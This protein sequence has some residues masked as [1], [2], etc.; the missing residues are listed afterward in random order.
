MRIERCLIDANW[1]ASTEVVYQFCRQ[2][3]Y[4]S[5][6]LPSHGK[7]VGA[8]TRPLNDSKGKRGDRLGL[9][10]RIPFSPGKHSIRHVIY[11][12]N[13]WKSFYHA[14]LSVELGGRGSLSL[15]DAGRD[16]HQVLCQQLT[17]EYPVTTTGRGRTV[18]EFRMRPE[19]SDNHEGDC[20]AGNCVA[21]SIEGVTL[22]EAPSEPG[23]RKAIPAAERP[24]LAQ[25]AGRK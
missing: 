19:A 23:A 6:L 8:A 13:Y 3:R 15:F 24:T 1:G 22:K 4:A 14:R 12:T 25:L 11:D 10:W 17:A 7:Y 21:A 5:V 16:G 9:N 18:E 2:S 20:M